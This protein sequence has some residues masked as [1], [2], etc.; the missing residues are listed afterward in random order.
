[1][2]I[3]PATHLLPQPPQLLGSLRGSTQ[4]SPHLICPT[5]HSSSH[6]PFWQAFPAAHTWLQAPQLFGSVCVST[7]TE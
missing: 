3:A 1:M 6:V 2:Q 5:G 7:H 4:V